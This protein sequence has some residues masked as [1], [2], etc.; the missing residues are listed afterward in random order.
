MKICMALLAAALGG[1]II[2]VEK[3]EHEPRTS[4][5]A[6]PPPAPPPAESHG[7]SD[8]YML[9]YRG[10]VDVVYAGIGRAFAKSNFRITKSDTPGDDN[11]WVRGYHSGGGYDVHI[12]MNRH[13]HKTRTTITVSSARF[14]ALHCREWTRRLHAEIG[15]QINE[16]GTD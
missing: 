11:W 2:E 12:H 6:P 8:S 4:K 16:S 3:D 13:D 15:K 9:K 10:K 1:C 7:H 5:P 14:D